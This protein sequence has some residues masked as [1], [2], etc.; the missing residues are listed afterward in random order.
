MGILFLILV[1]IIMG[2]I[3]SLPLYLVTNLVLWLFH[4]PFHLTLMQAFGICLLASVIKG[5]FSK[6]D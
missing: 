1:I 4:I 6:G 5:L 3:W 2:I